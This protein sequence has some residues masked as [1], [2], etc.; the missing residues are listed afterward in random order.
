M[1]D[2]ISSFPTLFFSLMI[3][4]PPISTRTDTLFP[5]TTLFRSDRPLNRARASS[6]SPKPGNAQLPP[7]R[8]HRKPDSRVRLADETPEGQRPP[9]PAY[10]RDGRGGGDARQ[11]HAPAGQGEA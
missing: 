11:H 10:R 6:T 1:S 5:Y 8:D 3:R 9:R 2:R 7:P 4:R